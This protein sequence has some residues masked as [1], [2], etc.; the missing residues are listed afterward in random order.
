MSL[1]QGEFT[2]QECGHSFD[3]RIGWGVGQSKEELRC[4]RCGA[5]SLEE[6]AYLLGTP[7]GEVAPE[8]YFDVALAPC[9]IPGWVGWHYL[10]SAAMS[11]GKEAPAKGPEGAE[12]TEN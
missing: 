1:S 11:R 12:E 9:C 2:C 7:D 4:P 6:T 10:S 3:R 5:E 8:D